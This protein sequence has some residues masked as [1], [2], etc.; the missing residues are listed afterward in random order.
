MIAQAEANSPI[1]KYEPLYLSPKHNTNLSSDCM[2]TTRRAQV[3]NQN[4]VES[5]VNY[6]NVLMQ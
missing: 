5:T 1:N 4:V 2:H 6:K 3:L